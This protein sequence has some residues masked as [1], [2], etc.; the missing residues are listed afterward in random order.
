AWLAY[1]S[2]NHTSFDASVDQLSASSSTQPS[3]G[4]GFVDVGSNGIIRGQLIWMTDADLDLH[5]IL[6]DHT[7][8]FYANPSVTF[9]NG[10]A[11]AV[12]DHDN[13]GEIIDAQPNLRIENIA[14]N[15]VPS[16]GTYTFFAHS[17][18][19]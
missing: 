11:N 18:A 7:E 5:L 4:G 6:P 2:P 13:Q 14:V 10:R 16:S 17:Y 9:N 8:V 19:T 3:A 15:G 12:L 1:N